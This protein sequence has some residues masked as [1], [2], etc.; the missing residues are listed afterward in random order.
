MNR[1]VPG[2]LKV[3]QD[4]IAQFSQ[5]KKIDAIDLQ[6]RV[7]LLQACCKDEDYSEEEIAF[8]QRVQKKYDGPAEEKNG[9]K[10]IKSPDPAVNMKTRIDHTKGT[11][12]GRAEAILDADIF[13]LAALESERMNR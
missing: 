12:I 7:A 2:Q 4:T 11:A 9:W 13:H 8:V 6:E 10:Y 5:D 1:F 3:V